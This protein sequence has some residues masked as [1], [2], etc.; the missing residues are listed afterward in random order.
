MKIA[1]GVKMLNQEYE[2]PEGYVFHFLNGYGMLKYLRQTWIN[3]DDRV[4]PQV[5]LIKTLAT[6]ILKVLHSS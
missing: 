3:F 2:F 6:N 4:F 5:L 1:K